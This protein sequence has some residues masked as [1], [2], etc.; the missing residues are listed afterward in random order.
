[1]LSSSG[2]Y[3]SKKLQ[4]RLTTYIFHGKLARI[5]STSLGE[6]PGLGYRKWIP[7]LEGKISRQASFLPL[8]GGEGPPALTG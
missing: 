3:F 4:K 7:A 1:M 8:W 5:F 2:K 6:K